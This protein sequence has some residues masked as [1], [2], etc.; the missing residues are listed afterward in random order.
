MRLGPFTSDEKEGGTDK[1]RGKATQDA[2]KEGDAIF[3]YRKDLWFGIR[4]HLLNI[5]LGVLLLL[6][7]W[8]LVAELVNLW[9]GLTLFPTPAETLSRLVDLLGGQKLYGV[10]VYSHVSASL[11][12]WAAGYA[13]AVFFGIVMG[14][15]LGVSRRT[16]DVGIIPIYIFQMIP[17]LAWVPIAMLIF[18]LGNIS[19]IFMIF[20]TALPPI[21]I[22][23]SSGIRAVPPNLVKA[24]QMTGA[25]RSRIFFHVL[26]PASAMS[27]INGL[28]IG[29]ANGW[30]VLIAAEM[31]V[32]VAIGLGYSIF[33]S[34]WSLDFEAAFVCIVIICMIGL[35]IEKL[36]F[37]VLEDKIRQRMG[38][39]EEG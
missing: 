32:G 27:V 21:A 13:L 38:L 18:G 4:N 12:R 16:H 20:M 17:G 35:V 31:V 29:L 34:R 23:T 28:R 6:V 26:L 24:A 2:L 5:V 14:I 22:S 33:Q 25:S 15:S 11:A 10:T 37:V 19:T 7:I 3:F 36:L 39:T 30:R 9:K 1:D 8:Y